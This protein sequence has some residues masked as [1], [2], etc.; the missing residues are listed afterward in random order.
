MS[1]SHVLITVSGP[2]HPGITA[3]LMDIVVKSG[4]QVC[5]MGQAVT[6]GLLS[7]SVYIEFKDKNQTDLIKE[8]LFETRN[9]GLALNYQL[10][11]EKD[12]DVAFNS[13]EKFILNCISTSKL[14]P[15]FLRDVSKTLASNKIN[16]LRIDNM[17]PKSFKSLEMTT[18]IPDGIDL[19]KL[20]KELMGLS[21]THQVDLAFLKD[22]VFR[23]SKR[24]IV[25][26]MD[27]TLIQSEVI[28][29]MA[30]A[31]GVGEEV[32][33]ITKRAMEGEIDFDQSLT[34]RV[35]KLKGLKVEKMK[36]IL[37][38]LQLTHGAEH[39]I[40]RVKSLG[41]KVAIISGGFSFYADA[42]REKLGLDY[43]FSNELEI[44][45]GALTGKVLGTIINAHQKAMLL[46]LIAQQEKISMEQVVAIGDGAN[47]LQ[48]LSLAGL[49][50]AYHAK[51]IVKK[52]A[53]HHMSHGPMTSILYFLGIPENEQLL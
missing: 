36:E 19:Q 5:D 23:R 9:M 45:N 25:F 31:L 17:S 2:D 49:G 22:N 28:D 10:I 43:A 41:Y 3:A 53:N 7:L 6:H 33:N 12:S 50:I 24:L 26:D 21:V 18:T 32:R 47:D 4:H 39:F 38:N 52:E 8:L 51:E 48:M 30:E 11:E 44:T 46:K 16:I 14:T 27:S 20:K 35:S 29:E 34:L 42:L 37:E 1:S 13:S 40:K 15:K